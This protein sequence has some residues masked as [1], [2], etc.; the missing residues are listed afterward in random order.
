[1]IKP[2]TNH[3]TL[4]V[5]QAEHREL[6]QQFH[7]LM[8]LPDASRG[9]QL[10]TLRAD[11]PLLVEK[12]EPLLDAALETSDVDASGTDPWLDVGQRVRQIV[13]EAGADASDPHRT[14]GQYRILSVLGRGGMGTVYEAEQASPR[15]RV[16]LKVLPAAL[17]SDST[18]RRFE[19]ETEAL[20]RLQHPGVAA[21]YDAG[22]RKTDEIV[23]QTADTAANSAACSRGQ[24]YFAMELVDGKPLTEYAASV[25]E[26]RTLKAF[27][28]VCEAVHYA[29]TQGVIHRDLKPANIIVDR[30]GRPRVVDFGVARIVDDGKTSIETKCGQLVGTLAYMSPEQALGDPREIDTRSDVFSLGVV[31]FELIAGQPPRALD[32][33]SLPEAVRTVRDDDVPRLGRVVPHLAGTD[34]EIVIS[35]ATERDRNRRYQSAIEL[36]RDVLRVLRDQPIEAR[37]PSTLHQLTRLAD[38]HRLLVVGIVMTLFGIALGL[39]GV[40]IAGT[41]IGGSMTGLAV[42]GL[43]GSVGLAIGAVA[44]RRALVELERQRNL[45]QSAGAAAK[46]EAERAASMQELLGSLFLEGL[47]ENARGK[48]VT[49]RDAVDTAA[50]NLEDRFDEATDAMSWAND[51]VGTCY[52]ALGDATRA[53]R[54]LRGALRMRRSV[55]GPDHENTLATTQRLATLLCDVGQPEEAALLARTAVEGCSLRGEE[56]LSESLEATRLLARALTMQGDIV[57]AHCLLESAVETG[58]SSDIDAPKTIALRADLGSLELRRGEFERAEALLTNALRRS[59]DQLGEDHPQA[60][61]I[62]THLAEVLQARGRFDEASELLNDG[63]RLQEKVLGPEH[64][65]T[66]ATLETLAE[67]YRKSERTYLA[68]FLLERLVEVRTRLLGRHNPKTLSGR[69]QLGAAL[70]HQGKTEAAL[71]HYLRALKSAEV[72]YPDGS[73]EEVAAASNLGFTCERLSRRE[74]AVSWFERALRVAS[75]VLLPDDRRL[76]VIRANFAMSLVGIGETERS[77]RLL[78]E[79]YDELNVD[80]DGTIVPQVFRR[81]VAD[82]REFFE[83]WGAGSFESDTSE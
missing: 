82:L 75:E 60:L 52:L 17:V 63:L 31:L 26:D 78:A 64:P 72:L 50:R 76:P 58:E 67:L 21:I 27:A 83:A 55:L 18:L 61:S 15:R 54:H 1:M 20:A 45:A 39:T 13:E 22:F 81:P 66:L 25:R 43:L 41:S 9:I 65:Q 79:C 34:I 56:G 11:R 8:E 14:F 24:P 73:A 32:R 57:E 36:G 5:E 47:P 33:S 71:M 46:L 68:S 70:L 30:R 2:V 51:L 7:R 74:E 28:R 4:A 16:A 49:V 29:H 80:D 59:E 19:H 23:E 37:S 6:E 3:D 62:R 48:E 40:V 12:L 10:Q 69:L 42:G 35:K 44:A 77:E 53:E 38:R